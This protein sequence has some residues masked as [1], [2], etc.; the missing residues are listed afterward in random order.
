MRLCIRIALWPTLALALALQVRADTIDADDLASAQLETFEKEYVEKDADRAAALQK[1]GQCVHPKVAERLVV[2]AAKE[3]DVELR[4]LALVLLREQKAHADV[5]GLRLQKIVLREV[6]AHA[7][8]HRQGK[9]GFVGAIVDP[10]TG[11]VDFETEEAREALAARRRVESMRAAAVKT[12]T[13]VGFRRNLP[14]L[15]LQP[16]LESGHDELVVATIE[17]Y[18]RW[19]DWAALPELGALFQ[20]YPHERK[21]NLGGVVKDRFNDK[22]AKTT[23]LTRFGDPGIPRVRPTVVKALKRAAKDITGEDFAT[24]R[25]LSNYLKRKDVRRKVK[26]GLHDC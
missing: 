25:E 26:A 5:F 4:T 3:R 16:F 14:A 11:E 24:C 6:R 19:K 1:L 9:S 8:E 2:L 22:R 18:G 10:I 21:W 23:W 15:D 20:F 12:L 13:E 17:F 7:W